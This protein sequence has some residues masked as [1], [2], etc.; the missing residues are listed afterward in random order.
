MRASL[1][2]KQLLDRA[3]DARVP[4][5][6]ANSR[7]PIPVPAGLDENTLVRVPLAG[8]SLGKGGRLEVYV[9]GTCSAGTSVTFNVYMGGILLVG[10]DVTSGNGYRGNENAPTVWINMGSEA[11]NM[12]PQAGLN[13]TI[14][15]S[16]DQEITITCVRADAPSAGQLAAWTIMVFPSND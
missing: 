16:G 4:Y 10:I 9:H 1:I 11:Q 6:L 8:G 14:D 15:T 5:I 3:V 13:S 2:F 7:G 12:Y